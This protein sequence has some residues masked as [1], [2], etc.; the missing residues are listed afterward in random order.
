MW[1]FVRMRSEGFLFEVLV[2]GVAG[3]RVGDGASGDHERL[4][5]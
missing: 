5:A 1:S 3:H 4:L 2:W